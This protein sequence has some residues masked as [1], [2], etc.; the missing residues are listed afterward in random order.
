MARSPFLPISLPA[1]NQSRFLSFQASGNRPNSTFVPYEVISA[2]AY[3]CSFK[4]TEFP[5]AA[6]ETVSSSVDTISSDFPGLV[7]ALP[8]SGQT[9]PLDLFST[10]EFD[11]FYHHHQFSPPTRA[12]DSSLSARQAVEPPL[13]IPTDP[14]KEFQATSSVPESMTSSEST[15]ATKTTV[16][17]TPSYILH[18]SES[19]PPPYQTGRQTFHFRRCL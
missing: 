4:M 6:P 9:D 17:S 5:K 12:H 18:K 2:S 1:F 10:P 14:A 16:V 11:F 8:E 3:A 15:A 13:S 19:S 7:F